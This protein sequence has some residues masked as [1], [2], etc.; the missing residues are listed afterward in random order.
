MDMITKLQLKSENVCYGPCPKPEDEVEQR[1]TIT[2]DGRVWLSR[3]RFG[4]GFGEFELVGKRQIKIPEERAEALFDA[5]GEYFSKE[6]RIKYATDVGTWKLTL[7][8]FLGKK[9][10][11]EGPLLDDLMTSKGGLSELMR[12]CTGIPDLLAFDGNIG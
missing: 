2:E 10:R 4:K 1:L 8:D 9:Y 6:N 12:A 3:Y 5:V 7:T 11:A